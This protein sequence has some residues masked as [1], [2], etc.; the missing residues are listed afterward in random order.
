ML[1]TIIAM[2]AW[3]N[4]DCAWYPLVADVLV[5]LGREE[6]PP[7]E[8]EDPLGS[9]ADVG[10]TLLRVHTPRYD[11][12]S[13]AALRYRHAT[14][15][16]EHLLPAADRG[17]IAEYTTMLEKRFGGVVDPDAVW[18]LASEVVQNDSIADAIRGL[19]EQRRQVHADHPS[20]LHVTG[21]SAQPLVRCTGS[22][23][24]S[25]GGHT[26][27]LGVQQCRPVGAAGLARP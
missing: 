24:G 27:G 7:A 15:T 17:L 20:V 8:A 2:G 4:D 13:E 6:S 23:R 16:V 14:S 3:E 10:L 22:D 1:L 21:G 26:R 18:E 25:A 12:G 19:E 9:I 11:R 5:A